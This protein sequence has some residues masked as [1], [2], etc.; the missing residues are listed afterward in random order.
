MS[1]SRKLY[2]LFLLAFTPLA[3]PAQSA[4]PNIIYIM[5]D[6][7]GYGDLSGYGQQ[8]FTTP[9]LDQLA[10]QGTKFTNA[11]AAAALCT[12]T[13]TAFYTGRWA[14]R[15]PVGLMEPLIP[16]KRDSAYGLTL[17]YP[18]VSTLMKNAGYETVLIGK[19]H[20]GW[21]PQHSPLRNGFDYFFGIRSGAADY[22]SHKN[23]ARQQ[24][25]YEMDSLIDV[26]GY[27][28]ELFTDR[29]VAFLNQPHS[30]PFFL[31]LT[32]NAP[33]WPW[34]GPND[35]PYPDSVDYRDGGSKET[36]AAMMKSLDAGIGNVMN[37][38][39]KNGLASNTLVIFTNDNGGEVPYPDNGI[40]SGVKNTLRE[41]GIRVPAFVRWPGKIQAGVITDE[42]VI[43]MDWTA[44][45]LAAGQAKP[46]PGFDLDGI[47][48]LPLLTKKKQIGDRTFYWRSSNQRSHQQAIREGHWK[49]LKDEKGEYLFD[50]SK[51]EREQNDLKEIKPETFMRLRTKW[52]AWNAMMLPPVPL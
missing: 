40:F 37:T 13:R 25:L 3:T 51:D 33:H 19:W 44:T 11:Y 52:A 14:Q 1:S 35:K 22:F 42:A 50:L 20:L 21:L 45:I 17:D 39:D 49:Y 9:N 31:V 4:K 16:R 12:P 47:D 8:V 26:K 36:Y 46:S 41:G 30:K 48:L 29:A 28:T 6:D 43:T 34:Q 24:D 38:I 27:L 23:D 2:S 18:S 5:T 15:T 32:Y 7:M 10:A